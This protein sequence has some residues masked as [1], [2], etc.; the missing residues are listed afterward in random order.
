MPQVKCYFRTESVVSQETIEPQAGNPGVADVYKRL[1][2]GG[3][4]VDI[5]ATYESIN[6][7]TGAVLGTAP[8]PESRRQSVPSPRHAMPS[9][10][11]LG[12]RRRIAQTVPDPTR[13]GA[14]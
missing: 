14:A 11:R 5:E 1:L 12:H 4:L 9:R 8:T 13:R 6:P 3:E 2:I 7:A 10:T